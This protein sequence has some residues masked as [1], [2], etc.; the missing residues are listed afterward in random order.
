M[1][2]QLACQLAAMG[3]SSYKVTKVTKGQCFSPCIGQKMEVKNNAHLAGYNEKQG[4]HDDDA[5]E[6]TAS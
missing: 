2:N 4:D 3:N 6:I 5:Q 1:K